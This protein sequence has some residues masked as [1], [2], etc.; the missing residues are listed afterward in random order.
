LFKFIL[1]HLF[2]TNLENVQETGTKLL[3]HVVPRGK[4]LRKEQERTR[5]E[6][7]CIERHPIV[8]HQ[9]VKDHPTPEAKGHQEPLP[10]PAA[11][12][13]TH[14]QRLRHHSQGQDWK[15][16]DN[17]LCPTRHRKVQ[18][19][20]ARTQ[21]PQVPHHSPHKVIGHAGLQRSRIPQV[22]G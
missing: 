4:E 11:N 1:H 16:K 10:N 8:F 19:R 15:W 20:K 3:R 17:G 2:I 5:W 9:P 6:C 21:V 18:K 22:Q 12:L 13:P 14:L 7:R